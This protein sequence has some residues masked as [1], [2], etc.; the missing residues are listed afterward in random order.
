MKERG[1][2]FTKGNR[3]KSR[4]GDKTM[5]R[6]VI[7]P[8][9]V[10]EN[11]RYQAPPEI[12]SD[13]TLYFSSVYLNSKPRYAVGDRLYLQEPCQITG[14]N[15]CK[16][17]CNS[18]TG[19]YLDD[20]QKFAIEV[21]EKE[22]EKWSNRKYPN[23]KTSARFMYKSLARTWFEVVG[24]RAERVQDITPYD[25]MAEGRSSSISDDGDYSAGYEWFADLW[26]LINE[27]RGFGW[28]K[29]PWVFVYE[30][31]LIDKNG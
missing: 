11:E 13:G 7:I 31:K 22:L 23:R 5:T 2:I 17:P 19:L 25:I 3:D 1:A 12:V 30:Y 4:S 14:F 6:R 16:E 15:V 26:D 20:N 9:P 10:T 28:D 8:Q 18:F 29:N 24:V 21:S 27:K